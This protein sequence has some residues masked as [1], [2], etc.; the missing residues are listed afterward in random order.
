MHE[1]FEIEIFGRI[2]SGERYCSY[3]IGEAKI[4]EHQLAI[5]LPRV[6]T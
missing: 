1:I 6:H 4:D 5:I 2:I 3:K